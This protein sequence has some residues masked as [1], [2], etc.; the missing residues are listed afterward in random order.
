MPKRCSRILLFV[1]ISALH[2]VQAIKICENI[3]ASNLSSF[4]TLF[5]TCGAAILQ[6]DT[7]KPSP[8]QIAQNL[9]RSR[10]VFETKGD[11]ASREDFSF[12]PAIP[13]AFSLSG[14]PSFATCLF[15]AKESVDVEVCL[16]SSEVPCNPALV[17]FAEL[18]S[19]DVLVIDPTRSRLRFCEVTDADIGCNQPP[20]TVGDWYQYVAGHFTE[21]DELAKHEDFAE[22]LGTDDFEQLFGKAEKFT[23]RG[24]V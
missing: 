17:R 11:W 1:L 24:R 10:N 7:A 19:E 6:A 14:F 12:T 5:Q 13:K 16:E 18:E 20:S 2:V 4:E 22:P 15:F 3:V 21:L 9:L 23:S 8:S